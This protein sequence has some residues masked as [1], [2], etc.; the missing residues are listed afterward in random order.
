MS[1][2][3]DIVDTS[4]T[5]RI[6]GTLNGF[7]AKHKK[8]LIIAAAVLVVVLVTVG[9]IASVNHKNLLKEFDTVD[10]LGKSYSDLQAM[11]T[12][13]EGYQAKYDELV[14]NLN[15]LAAKGKKYP[16]LK[17]EYLLGMVSFE[18]KDYQKAMDSFL[19][20]YSD[21]NGSYLGSLSLTNAAV[22]AEELGNDSL[23]LEYYTKVIDEFG[24]TA[25]E[26]PKALFG[27]ARLQE[28]SGN[29]ELAKATFQQLADQFPS[30]EFSKLAKD[31]LAFL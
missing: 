10:Q 24:L 21:A 8:A 1:N 2:N 15:D 13:A 18:K 7:L 6:E 22:S 14:K 25:A 12:D 27:Q 29:A 28:K 26:A 4:L 11:G 23:A 19:S 5:E 30:S 16:N 20:V 3:K 17:A 31:K 9:I